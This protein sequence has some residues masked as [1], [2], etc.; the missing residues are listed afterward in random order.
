MPLM[1]S[2][3]PNGTTILI[4][5][6]T[7]QLAKPAEKI[8]SAHRPGRELRMRDHLGSAVPVISSLPYAMYS[9]PV[10]ALG[11]VHVMRADQYGDALGSEHVDLVPEFAPRLWIDA[12]SRLVE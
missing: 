6:T 7:A 11:L 3:F 5:G 9:K 8:R 1:C 10:A 4:A 2:V 12:R